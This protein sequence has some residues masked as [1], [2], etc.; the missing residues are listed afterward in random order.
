M[1]AQSLITRLAGM[2]LRW[3]GLGAGVVAL[4]VSGLFGGLRPVTTTPQV[5]PGVVDKG[6]P[7]NVTVIKCRLGTAADLEPLH[8]DH[9]GDRW[10]VVLATIEVTS[11]DSRDD[12]SDALRVPEVPG[13]LTKEPARILLARDASD[14]MYLNPGMPERVGF[15]WEESGSAP[16]PTTALVEVYGKT[17]R[18]SSLTG[19]KEWL[20]TAVRAEVTSPVD[21]IQS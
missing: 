3:F 1:P 6:D 5:K 10:F 8:L 9:D 19:N 14:V 16:P 12:I 7:W 17:L 21:H 2:P 20:D 15:V 11:D 4:G 13:L 18:E